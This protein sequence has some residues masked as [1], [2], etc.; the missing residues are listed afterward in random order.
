MPANLFVAYDLTR[1]FV[2]PAHVTPRGIDRVDIGYAR[3]FLHDWPGDASATLLTP[4]GVRVIDRRRAMTIVDYAE[5]HW[6]EH[7]DPDDDPLLGRLRRKL[8]EGSRGSNAIIRGSRP[9]QI[10]AMALQALRHGGLLVGSP[11]AAALPANAVYVNTGQMGIAVPRFLAWLRT[12]PDIRSVFMLHDLIPIEFAQFVPATSSYFHNKMVD[13]AVIHADG[14]IT[15][16]KT[17]GAAVRSELSKRGRADMPILS[18]TLPVSSAFTNGRKL[19]SRLA[20]VP[21]FVVVS[22]IEPRKNQ[23]LLLNVW[24]DLVRT[25]GARAPKLVIAGT[26][27][28]GHEA[29]TGPLKHWPL[30]K[31]HVVEVGGLSTPALHQLISNARGLLMPSFAEG[32]GL[33]IIEAQALGIPVIA[34]DIAAHREVGGNGVLCLGV[35]DEA[36]WTAAV[37]GV[38]EGRVAIPPSGSHRTWPDYF[39]RIELFLAAIAAAESPE[40][41]VDD[42]AF[43][44][45]E[46]SAA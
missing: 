46:A 7:R 45:S 31:D 10:F 6:K 24:R 12:R 17:V 9:R 36:A 14:L 8:V 28:H 1:L 23:A 30:L 13:S 21:Y 34:S 11:G 20:Q 19:D 33:P 16:T 41:L 37:C 25:F 2:G 32:F 43:D 18:E 44:D 42:F 4:F 38:M 15:T 26:R 3:H 40:K 27:W 35:T 39:R 5:A 22:S 29:V